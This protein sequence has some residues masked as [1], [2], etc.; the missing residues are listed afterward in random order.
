M[1]LAAG[2]PDPSVADERVG[3]ARLGDVALHPGGR[4]S[5]LD[6]A[7]GMVE[8]HVVRE[9]P[10]QHPGHL[11]DV[12]DPRG[13]QLHLRVA[14]GPAVPE[15]LAGV[16]RQTHQGGEQAG[17]ARADLAQQ[18]HELAR[19]DREVDVLDADGAVVVDRGQPVQGEGA[20]WI[21][22]AGLGLGSG[23]VHQVEARGQVHQVAAAGQVARGPHPGAHA[24]CL[25][26]DRP[27]DP[28]EPVEAADGVRDEQ[29]D[30]QRPRAVEQARPRGDDTA[31][32]HDDRDSVEQRLDPV[33]A[34]GRIDPAA[35]HLAQVL[36][37]LRGRGGELDGADRLEGRDQRPTEA[38]PG[39]RGGRG[40]A[41]GDRSAQGRGQRGDDHDHEQDRA[42]QPRAGDEGRHRGDDQPVDEVDP[43]VGVAREAVRV[44]GAGDHLTGRGPDEP[45]LRRL[46]GEH[47][48]AHPEPDLHPPV[49]IGAERLRQ[50][51]RAHHERDDERTEPPPRLTSG[52]QV[53]D[54]E[55]PD[56]AGHRA[57][58]PGQRGDEEEPSAE[59]APLRLD[60]HR[61]KD[62]P[63]QA[64]ARSQ[65]REWWRS[66]APADRA[67]GGVVVVVLLH[68]DL[69]GGRLE[70]PAERPLGGGQ[71]VA[72][73]LLDDPT[74]LEDR[75]LLGALRR[76][77]AVGDEDA[78]APRDE[79]VRGPDHPRLGH[80]V[81]PGG[82]LVEDDDPHVPDEQPGEGDELLLAG[83]ERG[84][85]GAE[86]RV[87]AV[88]EPGDPL[89]E[90]EL[91]DGGLDPGPGH[92]AEERHVL[93]EGAGEHLGALGDD[94]DRRPQLLQVEVPHV[95]PAQQ[96][97]PTRRLDGAG[98][99]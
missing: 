60:A 70:E 69:V 53:G 4:E 26:D 81:H 80:R 33:L 15:D 79:P 87:E 74:R 6:A 32:D 24:G 43:A 99:Q 97:R 92:V 11:G 88:G 44:H 34:D 76:R 21:A 13:S 10:G 96:H 46:A 20:Q 47:R 17:L 19:L 49:R 55:T 85:A 38:G 93:G 50:D 83:R 48:G 5:R 64:R 28:A 45:A 2:E 58:R 67:D 27:G 71:P 14:H 91:G 9:R 54:D 42:G 68:G 22:R 82:G 51:E 62:L 84:A 31:L 3:P 86:H 41:S 77:Q 52:L 37:H 30:R 73:A 16:G 75:D 63:G 66:G 36:V 94:A 65:L 35:V 23:A 39:R 40:G 98:Q 72:G 1:D 89:G 29:R 7:A 57:E 8:G 25:G 59:Q 18:E 12:R 90:T 95:D 56:P 78:G 61:V